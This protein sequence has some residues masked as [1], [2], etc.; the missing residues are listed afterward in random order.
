MTLL[1][2]LI[3]GGGWLD[4]ADAPRDG[5]RILAHIDC[6]SPDVVYWS[7]RYG[8]WFGY[9]CPDSYYSVDYITDDIS[10]WTPLDA[11]ERMAKAL[12]VLVEAHKRADCFDPFALESPASYSELADYARSIM[13]AL[14][15]AEAIM[16]GK[17]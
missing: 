15:Q 16:E 11:P 17:E 3:D 13:Q 6:D 10:K 8:H 7:S 5:T 2:K 4:I 12:G 9:D 14:Q 1:Q